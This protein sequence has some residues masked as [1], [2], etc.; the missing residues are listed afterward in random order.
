YI[1]PFFDGREWFDFNPDT[2]RQFREW[3]R[4]SGP[5]AGQQKPPVPDLRAY[6]RKTPLTLEQVNRLAG[7]KWKSWDEVDPPRR[8]PG[9]VNRVVPPG[10]TA[11]WDN[12]WFAE[13]DAFRKHLVALHYSE[14]AQWTHEA[15]I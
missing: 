11:F 3:L 7:H 6:R 1:N 10:E 14:L 4:G 8:F 9:A 12:A 5:Y 13:W 2:L 15:G